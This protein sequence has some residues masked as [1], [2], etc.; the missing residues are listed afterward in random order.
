MCV[1]VCVR[2]LGSLV[3]LCAL[4]VWFF[5][6]VLNALMFILRHCRCRRSFAIWIFRFGSIAAVPLRFLSNCAFTLCFVFIR[7]GT[8]CVCVRVD[9]VWARVDRNRNLLIAWCFWFFLQSFI[10]DASD[11]CFLS[12]V[13][14]GD[15]ASRRGEKNVLCVHTP[16][17]A[18]EWVQT[19]HRTESVS[20]F[21][22][23]CFIS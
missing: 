23:F 19:T 1:C 11:Y 3:G 21:F 2:V 17:L 15:S 14:R 12:K 13:F 4:C 6:L 8:P 20:H 9:H 18:C 5:A 7:C 16:S 10:V 22:L